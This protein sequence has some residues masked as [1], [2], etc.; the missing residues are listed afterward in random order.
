MDTQK[1]KKAVNGI[2]EKPSL[3]ISYEKVLACVCHSDQLCCLPVCTHEIVKIKPSLPALS[4]VCVRLCVGP[5]GGAL[6]L[7]D[8]NN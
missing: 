5:A 4:L 7:A 3:C 8:H 6:G 2:Y 1:W